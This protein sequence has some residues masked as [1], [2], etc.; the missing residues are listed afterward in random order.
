MRASPT[1]ASAIAESIVVENVTELTLRRKQLSMPRHARDGATSWPEEVDFFVNAIVL[2]QLSDTNLSAEQTQQLKQ[3]I[4]V[5]TAH[6]PMSRVFFAVDKTPF[7]FE[8][9]IADAL[10]ELGW[11]AGLTN[12]EGDRGLDATATMREKQVV[13]RC[14]LSSS[15]IQRSG[16]RKAFEDIAREQI[17]GIAIVSNADFTPAAR[18]LAMSLRVHLLHHDE[19]VRLEE[20]IFGTDSWRSAAQTEHH[21]SPASRDAQSGGSAVHAA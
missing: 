19:L 8:H 11:S 5:S 18:Q 12:G 9:R 6:Y 7:P 14:L 10:E 2:P 20:R 21:R 17:D 13:V 16:V 3:F 4:D 1:D 15:A